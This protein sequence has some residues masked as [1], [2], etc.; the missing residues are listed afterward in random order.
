MS[1]DK[2]E[3]VEW[4][5]EK[6]Y[7]PPK[8]SA[9]TA[10]STTAAQTVQ[11]VVDKSITEGKNWKPFLSLLNETQIE[12]VQSRMGLERFEIEVDGEPRTFT[13]RKI[14]AKEYRELEEIRARLSS[15][16]DPKT[17]SELTDHVYRRA[18][19]FYIG[20]TD[21]EFDLADYEEVKRIIDSQNLRTIYGRPN[22]TP[23]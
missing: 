12:S 19:N 2:D 9:N 6:H 7:H 15:S 16:T 10:T 11:D 17:K 22:P 8:A 4:G 18:A 23:S 20:M 21:E 14:R 5:S 13:R 1:S 3:P